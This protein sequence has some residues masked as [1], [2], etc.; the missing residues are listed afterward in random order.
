[1]NNQPNKNNNQDDFD[2]SAED[3]AKILIGIMDLIHHLEIR[4]EDPSLNSSQKNEI[5]EHLRNLKKV[6]KMEDEDNDQ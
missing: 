5:K 6:L 4:L 2:I 3:S 1:M